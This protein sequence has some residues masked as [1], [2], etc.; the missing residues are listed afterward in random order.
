MSDGKGDEILKNAARVA[1]TRGMGK[2][3][4][5]RAPSQNLMLRIQD[6]HRDG[7]YDSSGK[8]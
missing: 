2:I 8:L 5:R 1:S 7:V 3:I 4:E 6:V